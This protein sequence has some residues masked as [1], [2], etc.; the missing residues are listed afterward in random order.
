MAPIFNQNQNG[1]DTKIYE[2]LL[3]SDNTDQQFKNIRS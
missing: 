2:T 1:H 3:Y